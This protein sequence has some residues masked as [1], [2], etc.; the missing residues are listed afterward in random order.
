VETV[1]VLLIAIAVPILWHEAAHAAFALAVT[2]EPVILQ[3]GFGPALGTQ[4]GRLRLRLA[5]FLLGGYC[6]YGGSLRPGDRALVAAAGPVS[7]VFLAALAWSL[8]DQ[9]PLSFAGLCLG[10]V[11][12]MSAGMALLTAFPARLPIG[13]TDGLAVLRALFPTSRLV[14]S[15]QRIVRRPGRPL[16]APFAAVL[17]LVAV[18]AFVA[19]PWLGLLLMTIFGLAYLGERG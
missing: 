5:P 15:S 12:I 13:E 4:I 18:L 2:R 17:A 19:S 16:R 9:F 14:L 1:A 3:V 10:Q 6:S 8:R 11:A 7:S